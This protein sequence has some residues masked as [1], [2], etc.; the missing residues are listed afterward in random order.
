MEMHI[1]ELSKLPPEEKNETSLLQWMRFLGG[2][3]RK[4]FEEMAKKNSE[5]EEAYDETTLV[6]DTNVVNLVST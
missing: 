6:S 5:L 3:T 4:D 2:K 1:L